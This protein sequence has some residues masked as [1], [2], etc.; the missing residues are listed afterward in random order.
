VRLTCSVRFPVGGACDEK[1]LWLM[2]SGQVM[3]C[4]AMIL[5]RLLQ[6]VSFRRSQPVVS[7]DTYTHSNG[8]GRGFQTSVA[9]GHYYV[10]APKATQVFMTATLPVWEQR[11]MKAE[12]VT[13]Y[14]SQG[15]MRDE[16]AISEYL[17]VKKD[18][19]RHIQNVLD[20]QQLVREQRNQQLAKEVQQRLAREKLPRITLSAVDDVFLPQFADPSLRRRK[21]LV[22]EGG[23][24]CGK[25]EFAR[26][27]SRGPT[28][29]IE[30]N[31][32]DTDYVDLRAFSPEQHDLILWDECPA[33]LVLKNKKLFQGQATFV[34]L[35]QTPTSRDAYSVFRF[36]CKMVVCSNLW[37][38]QLRGVWSSQI[39]TGWWAI[40]RTCT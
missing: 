8:R 17:K 13:Q 27:L 33:S 3:H 29:F 4:A 14:W 6:L 31:C 40:W 35:G 20:H 18:C 24:G 37:S 15:K 1:Q 28:S 7:G 25:T 32:A 16:E 23:T 34:Q 11:G 38:E 9:A 30:L 39:M 10:Q 12:W 19:K 2:G 22:L 26:S 5:A 21:F 36:N